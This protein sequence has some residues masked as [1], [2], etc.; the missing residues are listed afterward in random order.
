MQQPSSSLVP[1]RITFSRG[2]INTG[3]RATFFR[4]NISGYKPGQENVGL[5]MDQGPEIQRRMAAAY[6]RLEAE[7]LAKEITSAID[8]KTTRQLGKLVLEF[9][10]VNNNLLGIQKGIKKDIRERNRLFDK[11]KK[12]KEKEEKELKSLKGAFFGFRARVGAVSGA[13]AL[14]ELAEGDIAGATQPAIVAVASFL[15]EIINITSSVVLGG[16]ALRGLGGGRGRVVAPAGARAPRI[17]GGGRAGLLLGAGAAGAGLIGGAMF[18]GGS[19]ER[20]QELVA[21]A[22]AENTIA[23]EDVDRF[24]SQL[25]RFN[26]VIDLMLQR[27]KGKDDPTFTPPKGE[28]GV[29]KTSYNQDTLIPGAGG[30]VFSQIDVNDPEAKAFIATVRQLEGTAGPGGYNTWFGGRTDMD[31]SK[32][33]VSQVVAEQ[34]R[35]LATGEATYGKYTSAAVGAGQFMRPEETVREMG[36]DPD[37]VKY[38]PELQNK[39]ILFQAMKRR[40]VDPTKPLSIEDVRKLGKEWASFTPHYGQT[41]RTAGESLRI[42]EQN[43]DKARQLQSTAPTIGQPMLINLN[44]PGQTQTVTQAPPQQVESQST[45]YIDT[46]YPSNDRFASNLLLGAFT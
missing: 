13:I 1:K 3:R 42:Y 32:M 34:K 37:K 30:N 14:K 4:G 6:D 43:L 36:L 5:G 46:N 45:P 35:R 21:Q 33:T 24:S 41:G 39:M 16:L 12:L 11:K 18:G 44:V 29:I 8:T 25:T 17:R 38:T 31:L 7:G 26:K 23:P 28:N 22:T 15:P 2:R 27:M 20:R 40:G 10:Q 9:E 19:E